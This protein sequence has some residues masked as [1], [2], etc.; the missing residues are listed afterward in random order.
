MTRTTCVNTSAADA[1]IAINIDEAI[2]I[3]NLDVATVNKTQCV[4]ERTKSI[5]LHLA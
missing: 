5:E 2:Q 1:A 3:Q 4:S